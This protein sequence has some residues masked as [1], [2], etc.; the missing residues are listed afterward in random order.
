LISLASTRVDTVEVPGSKPDPPV[1]DGLI[2]AFTIAISVFT[3]HRSWCHDAP[4]HARRAEDEVVLALE[5]ERRSDPHRRPEHHEDQRVV[6]RILVACDLEEPLE[7][8]LVE[9]VRLVIG[10]PR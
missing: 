9:R 2:R 3:M 7:L 8:A 5:L 10:D 6:L 1:H 4:A